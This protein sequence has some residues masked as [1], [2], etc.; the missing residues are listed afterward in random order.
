MFLTSCGYD[1][2]LLGMHNKPFVVDKIVKYNNDFSFYR[3]KISSGYVVNKSLSRRAELVLPTG[4][5]N[6]GDTITISNNGH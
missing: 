3:T 6:I 4:M 2:P 1:R 5:F